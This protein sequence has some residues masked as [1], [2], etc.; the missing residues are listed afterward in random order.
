MKTQI[1]DSSIE[2]PTNKHGTQIGNIGEVRLRVN[3]VI[4]T[5]ILQHISTFLESSYL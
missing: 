5:N 3:Y 1:H 4:K 2:H